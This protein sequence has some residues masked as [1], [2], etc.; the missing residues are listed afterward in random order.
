[1]ETQEISKWRPKNKMLLQQIWEQLFQ[2]QT[3]GI[4]NLSYLILNNAALTALHRAGHLT[5]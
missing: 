5:N 3:A 1:M 4:I 2:Q